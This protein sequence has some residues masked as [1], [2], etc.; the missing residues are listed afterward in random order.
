MPLAAHLESG[1]LALIAAHQGL[2]LRSGNV[3][4]LDL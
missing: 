4:Q 1:G 3:L 2:A